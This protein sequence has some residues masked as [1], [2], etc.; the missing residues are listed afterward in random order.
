MYS[1][2]LPLVHII[3]SRGHGLL[4]AA[5]FIDHVGFRMGT[6]TC[7]EQNLS[8]L[9]L[10]KEQ[11]RSQALTS[12]VFFYTR[13][14]ESCSKVPVSFVKRAHSAQANGILKGYDVV[15]Y[16]LAAKSGQR[17]TVQITGNSNANVNVFAT[18]DQPG[19]SSALGS[20]GNGSD[21]TG[22]LPA[23]GKYKVQVFQ[24]RASARRG[25]AVPYK[26][27]FRID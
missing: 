11:M 16:T 14:A 26:I 23:S 1:D 9:G 15:E 17:M 10:L 22:A 7:S 3:E 13:Q 6:T 27:S 25:E 5:E 8:T 20:G 2:G 18:G 21:W 12:G 24:M 4:R 19:Q